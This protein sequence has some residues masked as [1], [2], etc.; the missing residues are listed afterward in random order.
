VNVYP[1]SGGM[2]YS[3]C[4]LL[5]AAVDVVAARVTAEVA[6]AIPARVTAAVAAA[7]A[8]Q[9]AAEAA[10][11]VAAVHGSDWY[12]MMDQVGA[13]ADFRGPQVG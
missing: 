12:A 2:T 11:Q 1:S 13:G 3:G 4:D 8:V 6:A 9:S 5:D 10:A 7:V